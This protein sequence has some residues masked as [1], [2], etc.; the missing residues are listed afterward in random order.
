MKSSIRLKLIAYTFLIIFI[1]GGSISW[2]FILEGRKSIFNTYEKKCFQF[3]ELLAHTLVN[4]LYF[5]DVSAIRMH[6]EISRINPDISYIYVMDSEGKVL[7]DGTQ[8]NPLSDKLLQGSF[9]QK[10]LKVN[11]WVSEIDG[12][13]FKVGG[14]V[15]SANQL[16][17]GYI[18]IGFDLERSYQ[19]IQHTTRMNILVTLFCLGIGAI[20]AFILSNTVTSPIK[21]LLQVTNEIKKGNF[22]TR[23]M[24]QRN[25]ELGVLAHSVNQMVEALE[26]N[27]ISITLLN[28]E[29]IE[30]KKVEEE[31]RKLH[32][33][34]EKRVAERTEE[35]QTSNQLLKK[36]ISSRKLIEDSLEVKTIELERSN[37]ELEQFAYIASHDLQEPLYIIAGFADTLKEEHGSKLDPQ[38]LFLLNRIVHAS[39]RMGSLIQSLLQ[40]ARLNTNKQSFKEVDLNELVKEIILELDLKIKEFNVLIKLEPLPS[41]YADKTQ[42]SQMFQNLISNS[43]KFRKNDIPLEVVIKADCSDPKFV[44]IIVKDNGIGFEQEFSSKI[45]EPFQRLHTQSEY[46]GNGLGLAICQKIVARHGGKINV[47]GVLNEG[48][49]FIITL[50]RNFPVAQ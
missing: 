13:T 23:I 32:N 2:F 9:N 37:Q 22:S 24:L 6:L 39:H 36:E 16:V 27:T 15:H 17:V 30:R 19:V 1:V 10:I 46:E 7:S 21:K 42:I 14:P 41:I 8:K 11:D 29:I 34:L 44:K 12:D 4:D 25:D 50:P 18:T 3:T 43:I 40:F 35:L 26:K 38:G 48:A 5:L 45:L 31:L 33:E 28:D 47:E 20:L 49:T